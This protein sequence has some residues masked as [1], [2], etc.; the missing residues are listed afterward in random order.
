MRV[1]DLARKRLRVEESV[2]QVQQDYTTLLTAD[3]WEHMFKQRHLEFG[4][5]V[6]LSTVNK[7]LR[8]IL[9]QRVTYYPMQSKY[10]E[11]RKAF[12]TIVC[13]SCW[14]DMHDLEPRMWN[15]HRC[16]N[17]IETCTDCGNVCEY[18]PARVYSILVRAYG[19]HE[20]YIWNTQ[21][22]SGWFTQP[23]MGKIPAFIFEAMLKAFVIPK[24]LPTLA[25]T[26]HIVGHVCKFLSNVFKSYKAPKD[27][28]EHVQYIL[29]RSPLVPS[30]CISY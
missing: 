21:E 7:R 17:P 2:E 25:P 6:V 22:V 9:T 1:R 3:I 23:D 27:V 18:I 15:F 30:V 24:E 29:R 19:A 12:E 28:V 20:K 14:N 16:K 5:A 4:H 26:S 11:A 10:K 8:H 13:Q